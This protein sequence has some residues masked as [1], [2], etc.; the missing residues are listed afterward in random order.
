MIV[1]ETATQ[2]ISIKLTSA[3]SLKA[4]NNRLLDIYSVPTKPQRSCTGFCW[5]WY[6][7]KIWEILFDVVFLSTSNVLVTRV[8]DGG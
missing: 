6:G 1:Y 2:N 7:Q 8:P 3:N 4:F 5:F